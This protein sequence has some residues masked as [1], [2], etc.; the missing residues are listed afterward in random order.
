MKNI[1][2]DKTVTEVK[3]AEDKKAILFITT[4]GEFIAKADGDCCSSTWIEGIILP[5]MGFPAKVISVE[6]LRM[7]TDSGDSDGGEI[8]FYGCKIT[9]D[10]GEI[11]IDYRNSSNGYYGGN[12][13]FPSDDPEEHYYFYGGVYGQN[14]SN[15]VWKDIK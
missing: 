6:D 8:K 2:I 1:L 15:N 12:L 4:E 5:A 13:V 11:D 14:V 3:I 7:P 9:T 10:K